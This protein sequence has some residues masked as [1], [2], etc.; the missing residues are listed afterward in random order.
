MSYLSFSKIDV[1]MLI[2]TFVL[3]TFHRSWK[4]ARVEAAGAAGGEQGGFRVRP[5]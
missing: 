4:S 5:T 3:A 2:C 1:K